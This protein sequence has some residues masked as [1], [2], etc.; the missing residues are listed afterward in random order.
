MLSLGRKKVAPLPLQGAA[1]RGLET[2][3]A[4]ARA[5]VTVPGAL[6]CSASNPLSAC[7][8]GAFGQRLEPEEGQKDCSQVASDHGIECPRPGTGLFKQPGSTGTGHERTQSF[9]G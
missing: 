6:A 7:F 3:Y 2:N 4:T 5:R 9:G 1:I 8:H